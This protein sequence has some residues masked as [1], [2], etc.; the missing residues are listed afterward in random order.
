MLNWLGKTV[1][2]FQGKVALLDNLGL[3]IYGT[4]EFPRRTLLFSEHLP[5]HDSSFCW[6]TSVPEFVPQASSV[7]EPTGPGVDYVDKLTLA[8][9]SIEPIE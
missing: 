8:I 5:L 2:E 7:F 6:N 9:D 1:R 3:Q 4:S